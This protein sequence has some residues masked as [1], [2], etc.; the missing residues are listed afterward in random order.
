MKKKFLAFALAALILPC[1]LTSCGD[2]VENAG[3]AFK[4]LSVDDLKAKSSEA[5][6]IKVEFWHSF[7]HNITKHLNPLIETFESNMAAE[8]IYID[9]ITKQIGGGYDGLRSRVNQGTKSNSIPTLILG[10]PD[11]FAD[12]IG[13]DILLPLDGFVNAGDK[14][15]IGFTEDEIQNDFVKTYWSENQL[16]GKDG[17]TITA[18]IPFNKSTEVMYY[19]ASA[20]DPILEQN[21]WLIDGQWANPTWEQVWTVSQI[22]KDKSLSNTLSWVHNGATYNVSIRTPSKFYPVYIDSKANFFITTARQWAQDSE[23]ASHVYTKVD[24]T[25][26][27]I[28]C[29]NND[30]AKTAQS[31]F[32]EKATSGLWNVPDKVNQSYG[33]NLMVNNEAFISIGSTAGVNNNDS[34]KYE[35]KVTRIPQK[36]YDNG[37]QAVIQQGTNAAIL[38]KNSNNYTRLA[39]WLLIR[40]LTSTEVTAQF[41]MN[42]GYLPVRKS[43]RETKD[44][45]EFIAD[46]NS[47]FGGA[48]AQAIVAA[49]AQSSYFYTDPAFSGSSI[50]RDI[51]DTMVQT[52]YCQNKAVDAAIET[53]YTELRG[54]GLTCE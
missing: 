16:I 3:E 48:T 18:G 22:L 42:T 54:F 46:A 38:T 4:L 8:E 19:N 17:Q 23:A 24:S 27:G 45:S 53:A 40:Y 47:I 44:F 50:V 10:Y 34:S 26:K 36:S 43:A 37:V 13:S 9:V 31:Y 14:E 6:P 28:V 25:G 52:I 5:A 33:S 41:S 21:G 49:D 15:N 7:G 11:H 1:T 39:A 35:M 29:F 32:L 30:V 12:Y 20:V 51:V 2:S